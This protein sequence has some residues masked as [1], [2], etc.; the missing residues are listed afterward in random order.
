MRALG[1]LS[2]GDLILL[3]GQQQALLAERVAA[4]E[5]DETEIAG[6]RA[7]TERARAESAEVRAEREVAR[8]ALAEVRAANEPLRMRVVALEGEL[9]KR[10]KGGP[11]GMPGLKPEEPA[12]PVEAKP[13]KRRE[14]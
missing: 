13:R 8:G 1:S 6:L 5:R 11:R 9:A 10:K 2:R 4:R 7:A 3:A 14:R 12:P